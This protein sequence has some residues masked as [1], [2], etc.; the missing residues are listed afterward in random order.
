[1]KLGCVRAPTVFG[2]FFSLLL[3][4]AFNSCNDGVFLHKRSDGSLF[5]LARLRAKTKVRKVLIHE[6]LFADD[7]ALATHS[8]E[9]LQRLN[10]HFPRAF[11]NFGLTISLKKTN[12]MGQ[13]VSSIPNIHIGNYT[14][15]LVEEFAYLGSTIYSNLSLDAELD[16]RI[17]KTAG[18]MAHLTKRVWENTMLTTN[19]KMQAYLACILSMLLY[20]SKIGSI[21]DSCEGSRESPGN[22]ASRIGMSW[23][24]Q[25]SQ[26]CTARSTNVRR[27]G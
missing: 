26:A 25:A 14:L 1:M 2:I 20:G 19:T 13:D 8:K 18:T 6:M 3:T 15:D 24:G 11:S 7:A 17:G 9:A 22:T 23:S 21:C 10:D 16:K 5:N 27:V 12:L 4:H